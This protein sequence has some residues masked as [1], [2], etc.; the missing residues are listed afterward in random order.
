MIK[1]ADDLEPPAGVLDVFFVVCIL[2]VV[3]HRRFRPERV[4]ILTGNIRGR[5]ATETQ[6]TTDL[7]GEAI[8][9]AQSSAGHNSPTRHT[10][11]EIFEN[12]LELSPVT[13]DD[14]ASPTLL[15]C[16]GHLLQHPL[17]KTLLTPSSTTMLADEGS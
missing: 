9:S 14:N 4:L 11:F 5:P 2:M 1:S 7:R 8:L 6:S 12:T 17:G 15:P 10:S 16:L 3:D 13:L